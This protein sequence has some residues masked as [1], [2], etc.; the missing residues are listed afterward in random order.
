MTFALWCWCSCITPRVPAQ[1]PAAAPADAAQPSLRYDIVSIR[2]AG[3][4][5][6]FQG[7]QP[8]ADGTQIV[9]SLRGLVGYAYDIRPEFVFGGPAWAGTTIFDIKAKVDDSDVALLGKLSP[10]ERA[11]LLA[12]VLA[13]RFGLKVHT[14]VRVL[15]VYD[16]VVLKPGALGPDFSPHSEKKPG[17]GM[18]VAGENFS[19]TAVDLPRFTRVL[20]QV[21]SD[22]IG[23]PIV[24]KTGL[25]GSYDFLLRWQAAGSQADSASSRTDI[26]TA[27]KEQLGLK[28]QPAKEPVSTVVIDSVQPPS[29]N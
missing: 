9:L 24:D 16:L 20:S 4:H 3:P 10:E 21:L 29:E 15:A 28:L 1:S 5:N 27:V 7:S 17:F 22:T 13:S 14:V 25:K 8:S 26:F 23:R 6:G 11:S 2:V 18:S 19:G 12:P